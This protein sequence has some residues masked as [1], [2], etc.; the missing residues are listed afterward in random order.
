MKVS[1]NTGTHPRVLLV[2]QLQSRKESGIGQAQ[3]LYSLAER[4]KLRHQLEDENYKGLVQSFQKR[5]IW[6]T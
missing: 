4:P 6:V 2:N 3:Y 5:K 1:Q